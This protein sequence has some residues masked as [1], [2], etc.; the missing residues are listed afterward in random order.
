V[1]TTP[2]LAQAK[3]EARELGTGTPDPS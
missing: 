2:S 1:P 3:E